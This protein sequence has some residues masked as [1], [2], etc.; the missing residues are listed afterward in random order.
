M[1]TQEY[2]LKQLQTERQRLLDLGK[3]SGQVAVIACYNIDDILVKPFPLEYLLAKRDFLA[4]TNPL[5]Y[6]NGGRHE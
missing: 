4:M 1:N 5:V 2:Y 3:P 6:S